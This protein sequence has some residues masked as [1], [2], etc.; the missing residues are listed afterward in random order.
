M[1]VSLVQHA[2]AHAAERERGDLVEELQQPAP[3]PQPPPGPLQL[4]HVHRRGARGVEAQGGTAR[5]WR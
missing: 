2:D 4:P 5:A 3:H 1:P